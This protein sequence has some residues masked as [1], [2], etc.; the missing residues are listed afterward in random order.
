MG[1]QLAQVGTPPLLRVLMKAGTGG[2][3]DLPALLRNCAL[4]APACIGVKIASWAI[5]PSSGLLKA[6][7]ET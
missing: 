3:S 7:N 4:S 6:R 2:E 5:L 1:I